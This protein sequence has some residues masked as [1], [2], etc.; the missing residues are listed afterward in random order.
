MLEKMKKYIFSKSTADYH[1]VTV[2]TGG[3]RG[4][5]MA[6]HRVGLAARPGYN[7]AEVSV[8]AGL[9]WCLG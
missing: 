2:S 4:D 5:F 7:A 3:G 9:L 8:T 1:P 6:G